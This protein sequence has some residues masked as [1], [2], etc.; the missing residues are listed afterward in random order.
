MQL[1]A[2]YLKE[3]EGYDSLI[4]DEGFAVYKIMTN[5]C[6]IKDIYVHPDFRKGK[7]ASDLADTIANIA[8]QHGCTVLVG[9][10]STDCGD[11]TAS[12]KV[13]LAYGFTIAAAIQGGILFKKGI[14]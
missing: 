8:K 10:V 9:S 11:P 13:L 14:E 4:T 3:R 1:L 12:T 5:E 6:Y 7:V 2:N